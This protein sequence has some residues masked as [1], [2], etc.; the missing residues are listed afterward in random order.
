M[1]S[2]ARTLFM[3]FWLLSACSASA[4]ART[5]YLDGRNGSDRNRGTSRT[6][7]FQSPAALRSLVLHPG[8]RVLFRRGCVFRGALRFRGSG[9]EEAPIVLGAY[10]EGAMPEILGSFRPSEW[11]RGDG[12]LYRT[13]IPDRVFMGDHAVYG[14][15]DYP[16]GG[17]PKRLNGD[18]HD[19]SPRSKRNT[20][21][22]D[23]QQRRLCVSTVDARPP[24]QHFIEVSV[25]TPILD[26]DNQSWIVIEDITFLFG[27]RM[28]IAV[29]GGHDI[30]V[31][32]CVSAFVSYFGNPNITITRG[33][34]RVQ[35]LDCFLYDNC[36]CGVVLSDGATQCVVRGCTIVKGRSNDGVTCHSGPRG[37][38]GLPTHCTG[39]H[40]VV[41]NNVIGLWPENSID[42]TSGDHHI[43]RNNICYNDRQSNILT[44]H[45][46]D[47]I[48]IQ[49]N[50]CFGSTRAGIMIAENV[51]EGARGDNRVVQNLV[52]NN[53]YPGLEIQARRTHVYNNTVVNS[54]YRPALRLNARA[55]GSDIRNNIVAVLD[56][57]NP[58]SCLNFL[59]SDPRE[60]GVTLD[61]NLFFH[62]ADHEK[63]G[64]FFRAAGVLRTE[65]GCFDPK[66]FLA[67]YG[68]GRNSFVARPAFS[69]AAPRYFF[70]TPKSPAIDAGVDV[71]L[72]YKGK[73]P[74]LGWKEL[75][76]E[77]DAPRYPQALIEGVDPVQDA[78][79]VARWL[80]YGIL[81]R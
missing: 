10:G 50:L 68:T 13:T 21:Y 64:L 20:F 66:S 15:F 65:D 26:L 51:D 72:P 30:I 54:L 18:R 55:R 75:G 5:F 56:P 57:N 24:A 4:F 11:E 46:A 44:G 52:Y 27:N 53:G 39:D 29:R 40:N 73:A 12:E 34:S 9:T 45:G 80:H 41:E 61:H 59:N 1:K 76:D 74:D 3:A 37:A 38:A 43:V 31:R 81:P 32:R 25:V 35:I 77:K 62:R 71:G 47:H 67:K 6:E 28:H 36:N 70:L 69:T 60:L 17:I 33:A 48:L 63:P 42:I 16:P 78:S 7:A 19:T 58:Q 8:D 23:N 49:N 14:V 2:P 22:F 79:L